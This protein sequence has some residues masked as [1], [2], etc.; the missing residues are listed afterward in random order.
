VRTG[1]TARKAVPL[2]LC[3]AAAAAIVAVVPFAWPSGHAATR[4]EAASAVGAAPG[5]EYAVQPALPS[6]PPGAPS[7]S[8]DLP[9]GGPIPVTGTGAWRVVPGTSG[10]AG[11]GP[12]RTYTVEVEDGVVLSGGDAAL[13]AAVQATLTDAR[14]WIGGGH[15]AVRRVDSGRPALR[16]RM[17]SQQ[18]AR[19]RCGY[20]IPVDV[21]CRDG[22]NVYLSSARWIRGAV[23]FHGDLAGYRQYMVNHEVGHFFGENHRPCPVDGGPAPV[24]MQQTFSTSNNE[25]ADITAAAP[26]GVTIP[27]DGKVCT[28]NAWPYP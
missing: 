11:S 12:V 27:R 28:P 22:D 15:L 14:S 3:V 23:A 20:D 25:I 1:G 18:T 9:D 26:Q 13:G 6:Q 19:A 8:A 2:T 17:A 24:M 21:S 5:P 16:I 10:V 4:A 7:S